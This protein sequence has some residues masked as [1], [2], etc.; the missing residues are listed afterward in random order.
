MQTLFKLLLFLSC[1]GVGF[2]KAQ[3]WTEQELEWIK[4]NPVIKTAGGP[5]WVPFDYVDVNGQSAG[6]VQTYLAVV[7]EKTG[8]KFAVSV[9]D[10]Y[11]QL[12]QIKSGDLDLLPAVYRDEVQLAGLGFTQPYT[13]IYDH[14]FIKSNAKVNALKDLDGLTVAMPTDFARREFLAQAF[15][16]IK[17]INAQTMGD[18][19][20]LVLAGQAD[21]VLGSYDRIQ[22]LLKANNIGTIVPFQA[23]GDGVYNQVYMAV[24]EHMQ[25]LL[26]ILNKALSAITPQEQQT[27]IDQWLAKQPTLAKKIKLTPA[28]KQWLKANP[29]V[30][31][32]A[33]RQWAP[34]EFRDASGNH[35]GIAASYVALIEQ[36]S[37]LQIEVQTDTWHDVLENLQ[38]KTLH[39]LSCVVSTDERQQYINFTHPYLAVPTAVYLR[40]EEAAITD[41]SELQ[42]RSVALN[43]SSY[44][45]EWMA[46]EYPDIEL[47]LTTS[48]KEAIEA[49]SYGQA[50]AYIGNVVVADYMVNQ[51]LITNLKLALPLDIFQTSVSLGIRKDLPELT[52][53]I[54]KSLAIISADQH[55]AIRKQWIAHEYE[56]VSLLPSERDFLSRNQRITYKPGSKGM[57]LEGTNAQGAYSGINADFLQQIEQ[58]LG[59]EF[60][61]VVGDLNQPALMTFSHKQDAALL[62]DFMAL[63]SHLTTD[64]VM[65][66]NSDTPFVKDLGQIRKLKIGVLKDASFVDEVGQIYPKIA[67]QSIEDFNQAVNALNQGM[68]DALLMPFAEAR[69]Q[70]NSQSIGY[71]KIV[72]KTQFTVAYHFYVSKQYPELV[73]VLQKSLAAISTE[74]KAQIVDNWL[75][76]DILEK[77]SYGLAIAVALVL[78]GVLFIIVF[79]NRRMMREINARMK[80][81]EALAAEK[82]NFEIMF[83]QSG[84]ANLIFQNSA[85]IACNQA[86]V[87]MF[88]MEDKQELLDSGFENWLPKQQANGEDSVPFIERMLHQSIRKMNHRFECLIKRKDGSTFWADAIFTRI[89]YNGTSALYVVWRDVTEQKNMAEKLL[90]ASKEAEEANQAKSVF[91]ANMSHEIR[92]PM[93]AIIGFT[94]LLEEQIKEPHLKSY[95]KTIKSAGGTLL[96]LINDILDLSKIEAGK[97]ESQIM[98]FNPHEYFDDIAQIFSIN[99]QKKG[100]Q[101]ILEIDDSVPEQLSLD[102]NHLRQVLFNLLGNAIKFSEMGFIHLLVSTYN[103]KT[104]TTG[105]KIVVQDQGIGIPLEEQ[106]HIFEAF[107]QQRNQD[108]NRF[109]GTGL[110]L[111]ISKKLIEQM[112]GEIS[113]ESEVGSGASFIIKM[114][115]IASSESHSGQEF[116][117]SHMGKQNKSYEFHRGILLVVDD[118][119]HNRALIAEHFADS[120]VT[121]IHAENGLDAVNC[122]E[123]Y[124]VDLVLMDIRMPVMDG[125]EAA[126]KIKSIDSD[127]PIVALTASVLKSDHDRIKQGK[128]DGFLPKP[129]IKSRLMEMV[130]QFISHDV[131]EPQQ[132]EPENKQ[133][134]KL[135][136]AQQT[137]IPDLLCYLNGPVSKACELAMAT[138]SMKD[139]NSFISLL[140]G[141]QQHL[142][143]NTVEDYWCGLKRHVDAFDVTAIQKSLKQFQNIKQQVEKLQWEQ[144]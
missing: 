106:E 34:F 103:Q 117:V 61:A 119:Y 35:S 74:D 54:K 37:G 24:P 70:L 93:N 143:I 32:G 60:D 23:V 131:T 68:I 81:E 87:D 50:D 29:K 122:V 100:L 86:V 17:I 109:S 27:I 42:G 39:G 99:M 94:E 101:L 135:N 62:E 67:L 1:W 137:R 9:D 14:I 113:V 11:P 58:L 47:Y 140:Q 144:A 85:I 96:M 110:G 63:P 43:K 6:I 84:D 65:V 8:L 126:S 28:E 33:D 77:R 49:V 66:M 16:Q 69:Y 136:K 31:F 142:K 121:T 72:G 115:N 18:S 129:I 130:S 133:K 134:Q 80:T 64:V 55:Q 107:E 12:S 128:F 83:E 108:R 132:I 116:S 25:M 53:I 88:G 56:Q 30:V 44:L 120:E 82:E 138:Q 139:I 127:I 71:L 104:A 40:Q 19:I 73:S 52:S 90:I 2:A 95:V 76:L 38:N 57:P 21:A 46:T 15:P 92:T 5:D 112:G 89:K 105:L 20:A 75:A 78:S 102:I 91:L 118:N 10:W 41:I 124:A 13:P 123:K 26:P 51:S 111:A 3:S 125:Y 36:Y 79:W 7:A 22:H 4:S 114:P 59:I 98:A 141:C 97:I 48:N 45:N